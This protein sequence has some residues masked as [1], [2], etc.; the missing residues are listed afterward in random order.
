MDKIITTLLLVLATTSAQ[1]VPISFTSG[2]YF[3]TAF[4]DVDGALDGPV[5]FFSPPDA[6]PIAASASVAAAGGSAQ[7]AATADNFS[8]AVST[9]A[10]STGGVASASAVATF[11][12]EFITP[13]DAFSLLGNFDDL[14][15]GLDAGSL[16]AVRLSVDGS[17][18][19]DQSFVSSE[20]IDAA[21]FQPAGLSGILELVLISTA[22]ADS[23]GEV[24]NLATFN[25]TLD[26]AAVPEPA[27][28]ALVLG[29][30]GM[31]G[32]GRRL[33]M[34]GPRPAP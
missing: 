7:A 4:A 6:L 30:L 12:G 8:L 24:S 20:L 11:L 22:L 28:L 29:G 2:N 27:T 23:T 26:A 10:D 17:P 18:L 14:T 25:F 34:A 5:D 9:S 16:L 3:I 15:L 31:L 33:V 1:A 32:L 21:F 19:F 13:G